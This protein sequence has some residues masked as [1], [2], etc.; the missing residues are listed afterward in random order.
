MK[1]TI[2]KISINDMMQGENLCPSCQQDEIIDLMNQLVLDDDLE[3][4]VEYASDISKM[5]NNCLTIKK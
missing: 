3:E 1:R 4:A 5:C 2:D